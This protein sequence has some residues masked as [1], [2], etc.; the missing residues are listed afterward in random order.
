LDEPTFGQ[1]SKNTFK[2]LE[3]LQEES[4]KGTIIIMVTHDL[5]IIHHFATRVW[6]V[7]NGKVINDWKKDKK[8][9]G[10]GDNVYAYSI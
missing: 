1:D 9:R 4:Q 5:N 2:L 8:K 10:S 7:K 3:L 6:E